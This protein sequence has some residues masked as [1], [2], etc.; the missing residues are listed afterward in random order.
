MRVITRPLHAVLMLEV[1]DAGD[2]DV[3]PPNRLVV[4]INGYQHITSEWA[5][6]SSKTKPFSRCVP[7]SPR[8]QA[9]H[10]PGRIPA[11]GGHTSVGKKATSTS[12]N[13]FTRMN[14]LK[15]GPP[16]ST[17]PNPLLAIRHNFRMTP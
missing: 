16:L 17:S 11:T 2:G 8:R 3:R 10:E 15:D 13:G 6:T 1:V 5:E 12:V 4:G 9:D 7:Y 14:P